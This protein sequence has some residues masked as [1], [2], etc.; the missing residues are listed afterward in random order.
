MSSRNRHMQYRKSIYRKRR[1]RAIIIC[2]V[3]ILAVAFA[4]F[5]IVG[6]A[7]HNKTQK[8]SD[9]EGRETNKEETDV[10]LPQA[11]SV[12]CY[13]LPLLED[14][15]AFSSRLN[16]IDSEA[17]GVC[18]NLNNSDGTLLFRSELASSLSQLAVHE[19]A[20]SLS[21]A[22]SSIDKNG[23]YISSVLYI[24]SFELEND[25]LMD[26]ELATWGAVACEALREGVGDVLFIADRMEPEQIDKIC[27][28]AD[29]VHS[30]VKNS[31]IGFAIPES[32]LAHEDS[33]SLIDTLSSHFNYLSL[34]TTDF[35]SEDDPIS[36]IEGKVSSLQLELMYYKM[37]VL[38]PRSTD[39][40]LQ[41]QYIEA[42]TKY[43]ISSW[44]ILP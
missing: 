44:Q 21:N 9:G 18:V 4:L 36:F 30:T 34:D 11:A 38:L 35:R 42:V 22:I 6:T 32:I 8:P 1:I 15:S 5:M 14:G 13:A 3:L 20:S 17:A 2:T 33:A 26:V 29:N 23:Y 19:D 31:I 10:K 16:A 37:R 12:G 25:L 24:P 27:K 7:L 41:R 28:L 43:N 39:A 40:E